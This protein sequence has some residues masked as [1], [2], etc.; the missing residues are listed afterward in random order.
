MCP[1]AV[2]NWAPQHFAKNSSRCKFFR[3]HISICN[4]KSISI[5]DCCRLFVIER[6]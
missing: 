5:F 3:I 6:F 1:A 4:T 2:F